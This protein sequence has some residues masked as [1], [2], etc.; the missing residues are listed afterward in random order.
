MTKKTETIRHSEKETT[1]SLNEQDQKTTPSFRELISKVRPSNYSLRTINEF[2][3]QIE[4]LTEDD[5][6][7]AIAALPCTVL[8]GDPTKIFGLPETF[9]GK[10]YTVF[11]ACLLNASLDI[12]N[13]TAR[14]VPIQKLFIAHLIDPP[15]YEKWKMFIDRHPQE[16]YNEWYNNR[17]N[18]EDFMKYERVCRENGIEHIMHNKPSLLLDKVYKLLTYTKGII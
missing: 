7:A 17:E 16:N 10:R 13:G 12:G 8:L 5:M 18:N 9:E 11:G 2:L 14:D 3:S 1:Q 4:T 15:E 6:Q